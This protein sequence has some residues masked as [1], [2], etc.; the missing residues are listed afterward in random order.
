MSKTCQSKTFSPQFDGL[1]RK[2]YFIVPSYKQK[3]YNKFSF[4]K[5]IF[6]KDWKQKYHFE[7]KVKSYKSS[8][9]ISIIGQA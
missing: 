9:E 2:T 3:K 8:D 6:R 4:I 7:V 1:G 5:I